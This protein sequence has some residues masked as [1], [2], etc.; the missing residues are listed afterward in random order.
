MSGSS[1]DDQQ[2]SKEGISE[3]VLSELMEALRPTLSSFG[4]RVSEAVAGTLSDVTGSEERPE[5]DGDS[6][7]DDGDQSMVGNLVES[8]QEEVA[9]FVEDEASDARNWAVDSIVDPLFSRRT[10]GHARRWADETLQQALYELVSSIDDDAERHSLY[11][12]LLKTFRP[13]VRTTVDAVFAVNTRYDLKDD[14]KAA[15]PLLIQGRTDEAVSRI[16]SAFDHVLPT[17]KDALSQ[18][19]EHMLWLLQRLSTT[20]LEE[21]VQDTAQEAL[22]SADIESRVQDKAEEARS[23]L[24]EKISTLQET[25]GQAQD[26]FKSISGTSSSGGRGK[27]GMPPSGVPPNGFPPH[28]RPPSGKPPTGSPPHGFP[29]SGLPPEVERRRKAARS[30]R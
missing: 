5:T 29:P 8:A 21:K 6:D 27:P 18:N 2:Q 7:G 25:V 1:N 28:G 17:A 12:D 22:E 24:Q 14:L 15:V 4:E 11:W 16:G 13:I 23:T 26:Q 30:K 3:E 10:H 9:G 19:P 20:L